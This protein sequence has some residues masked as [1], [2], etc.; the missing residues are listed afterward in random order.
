MWK[1]K[2]VLLTHFFAFSAPPPPPPPAPAQ[3]LLPV[4][5]AD[6]RDWEDFGFDQD[7]PVPPLSNDD[8]N[9]VL[10]AL[11][12]GLP[13]I[14]AEELDGLLKDLPMPEPGANG[15]ISVKEAAEV[16]FICYI[17][18]YMICYMICY[19]YAAWP[20]AQDGQES[21]RPFIL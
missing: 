14:Y 6:S 4:D 19:R 11:F 1:T 18:C 2:S 21:A 7:V 8:I 15:G 13:G 12:K 17:V 5:P 16:C 3:L 9:I 10:A 20:F